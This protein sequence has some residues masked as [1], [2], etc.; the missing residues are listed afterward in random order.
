[1]KANYIRII[2]ALFLVAT[3]SDCAVKSY[4]RPV[5]NK[6][7][8]LSNIAHSVDDIGAAFQRN[9]LFKPKKNMSRNVPTITNYKKDYSN[10]ERHNQ[11]SL[12]CCSD[13][14]HD[15]RSKVYLRSCPNNRFWRENI[16]ELCN[17]KTYT[18]NSIRPSK[19]PG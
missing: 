17:N 5:T 15:R 16:K 9:L 3:L 14:L 2:L 1:M 7:K 4:P 8:M 13:P 10:Y 11:I 19:I 12:E 6:E 18:Q